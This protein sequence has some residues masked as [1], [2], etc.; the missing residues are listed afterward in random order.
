MLKAL[1]IILA[2]ATA[3]AGGV[4]V[5]YADT[6]TQMQTEVNRAV[7]ADRSN[8]ENP[9]LVSTGKTDRLVAADS[10]LIL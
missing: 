9:V 7:K 8:I 10:G 6:V 5:S 4:V 2:G 3:V 1:I